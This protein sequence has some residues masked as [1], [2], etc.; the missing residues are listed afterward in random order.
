M[1]PASGDGPEIIIS[2]SPFTVTILSPDCSQLVLSAT[3]KRIDT[4]T[5]EF[6]ALNE[7]T[8]EK[9][10]TQAV[11]TVTDPDNLIGLGLCALDPHVVTL[12]GN[13]SDFLQIAED[14]EAASGYAVRLTTPPI[15][16]PEA[17]KSYDGEVVW[18]IGGTVLLRLDFT[19]TVAEPDCAM[20]RLDSTNFVLDDM[21]IDYG[22]ILT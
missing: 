20:I 5:I 10:E 2:T 12:D 17:I 21:S 6:G 8:A 14:N 7:D 1:I 11:P 19:V 4:M 16:S 13:P 22:S 18:A 9:A 3:P 15:T